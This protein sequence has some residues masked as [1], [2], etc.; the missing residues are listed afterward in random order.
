ML[1]ELKGIFAY[2]KDTDR[3]TSNEK[4]N[5]VSQIITSSRD[6]PKKGDSGIKTSTDNDES[7]SFNGDVNDS[8]TTNKVNDGRGD[9]AIHKMFDRSGLHGNYLPAGYTKSN[10]LRNPHKSKNTAQ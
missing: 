10:Y 3:N 7:V 6:D 1:R 2:R 8:F 4:C 9:I 5:K